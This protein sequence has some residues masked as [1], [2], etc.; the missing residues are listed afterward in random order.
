VTPA[1]V[2]TAATNAEEDAAAQAKKDAAEAADAAPQ[3]PE[4]PDTAGDGKP[5]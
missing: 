4:Q 1:A 5:A 2:Q 3:T